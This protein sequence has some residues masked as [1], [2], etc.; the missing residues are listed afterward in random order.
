[1]AYKRLYLAEFSLAESDVA[2]A[3]QMQTLLLECVT[4]LR[5]SQPSVEATGPSMNLSI[6]NYSTYAVTF[7]HLNNS[8]HNFTYRDQFS[9]SA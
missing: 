3:L 5:L 9:N 7:A 4:Y 6:D 8:S 1:V 2:I